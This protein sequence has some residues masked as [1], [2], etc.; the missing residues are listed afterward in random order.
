MKEA[1]VKTLLAVVV[2][3]ALVYAVVNRAVAMW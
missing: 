3:A 2:Y 1:Q